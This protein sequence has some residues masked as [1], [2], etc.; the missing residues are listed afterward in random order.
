[1]REIL[2][3]LFSIFVLSE[4][5]VAAEFPCPRRIETKQSLLKA[6]PHWESF[7]DPNAVNILR[8]V[9]F[10]DGNPKEMAE[11]TPGFADS[12][13]DPVW[14]FM[15]AREGKAVDIWQVCHYQD[16]KIGLAMRLPQGIGSCIV[17][18]SKK[19]SPQIDSISCK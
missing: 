3:L 7:P 10:Y 9:S 16:S 4:P 18:Y 8:S 12:N 14:T 15:A 1:M 2:R 13:R 5:V 6:V 17:K 11:L 19:V